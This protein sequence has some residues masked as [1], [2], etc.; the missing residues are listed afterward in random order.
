VRHKDIKEIIAKEDPVILEIGAHRGTDTGRF[1]AEFKEIRLYCF[2]PDPRNIE[3]FKKNINDKRCRLIEAAVSDRDGE[4]TLHMS[5]G[6]NPGRW[7]RLYP[8]LEKTRLTN[9][10]SRKK[11]EWDLSSSIKESVSHAPRTPWLHFPN[12]VTVRTVA[13]DNWVKGEGLT[14][15][16]FIWS[17]VQGAE[18]DMVEGA[19]DTLKKVDYLLMEYGET[20]TYPLAMGRRETI[21]LMK[22]H[23]F[24]LVP[25]LSSRRR[26][27]ELLFKNSAMA[28][29]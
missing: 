15:I 7:W 27:G 25:R 13:L 28:T 22:L 19:R 11:A 3:A 16:D 29:A 2:E 9:W 26:V 23:G 17:D 6:Y 10:L 4:T 21:M 1:L 20:N 5:S 18:R 14:H 8:L 24:V 12:A